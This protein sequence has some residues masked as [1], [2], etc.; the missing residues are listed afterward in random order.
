M[1]TRTADATRVPADDLRRFATA[2]IEKAGMSHEDASLVADQLV[3]RDLREQYP[4]ALTAFTSVLGSIE[5]GETDPRARPTVTKELGAI[6]FLEAHRAWGQVSAVHAMRIS[7]E[8]A[9]RSGV[10][11]TIV[12]N[13]HTANAMFYYPTLAIAAGMVGMAVT[14]SEPYQPPWGGTTKVLGNQAWAYGAP[15]SRNHPILYDGSSTQISMARI[16]D[17]ERRGEPLPDGVALDEAGNPTVDPAAVSVLLPSGGHKGYGLS[18]LWEVL[19]SAL[20]DDAL[21]ADSKRTSLFL[22]AID[23][24]ASVG[25]AQFMKTV[26]ELIDRIHASPPQPGVDRVYAPGERGYIAAAERAKTGIPIKP[27]RMAELNKIGQ[28]YGV[29]W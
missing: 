10:G 6:T 3:A 15:A 7:I 9:S 19:T 22:M 2:V 12:R 28:K 29:A 20:A 24:A 21:P 1:T 23:P 14:N 11:I 5:K 13:A 8:H 18:V 16:R 4:H 27:A 25:R 17:L 26:D